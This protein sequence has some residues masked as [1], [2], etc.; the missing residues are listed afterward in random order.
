MGSYKISQM[1]FIL[2]C[3]HYLAISTLVNN[4]YIKQIEKLLCLCS[5]HSLRFEFSKVEVWNRYMH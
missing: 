3:I 2:I 1:K 4:T 5:E